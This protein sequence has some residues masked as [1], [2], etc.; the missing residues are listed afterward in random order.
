[1]NG[2]SGLLWR[3]LLQLREELL[4]GRAGAH[5]IVLQCGLWHIEQLGQTSEGEAKLPLYQG[6]RAHLLDDVCCRARL[7]RPH[8]G[9][10]PL[11]YHGEIARSDPPPF[12][13]WLFV[14]WELSRQ[15]A[16][17][18]HMVGRAELVGGF[19]EAERV[20]HGGRLKG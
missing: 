9:L 5:G 10:H 15:H 16:P 14:G 12:G 20:T 8:L 3:D 2:G 6:D 13:W 7:S 19:G 4:G 1:M 17:V 18:E 11:C